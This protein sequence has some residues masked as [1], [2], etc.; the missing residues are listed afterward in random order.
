MGDN[1]YAYNILVGKSEA[2]RPLGRHRRGWEDNNRM[3]LTEMGWE[4]VDWVHLDQEHDNESSGSI[5]DGEFLH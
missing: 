5:K 1:R 2:K 3:D 4:G